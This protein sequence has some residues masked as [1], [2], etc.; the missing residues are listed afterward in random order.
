LRP[1]HLLRG[2]KLTTLIETVDKNSLESTGGCANAAHSCLF[3]VPQGYSIR[4]LPVETSGP[5]TGRNNSVTKS[6]ELVNVSLCASPSGIH[7][8]PLQYA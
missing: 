1:R 4:H 3:D 2:E 7:V 8:E 6:G 5:K